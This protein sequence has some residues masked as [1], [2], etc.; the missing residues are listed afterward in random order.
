MISWPYLAGFTD[1][2]GSMSYSF[3]AGNEGR[4][5]R[6]VIDVR[7]GQSLRHAAVLY[8][9]REFLIQ[10]GCHVVERSHAPALGGPALYMAVTAVADV[11]LVLENMLP[12]LVLKQHKASQILWLIQNRKRTLGSR[13]KKHMR[14]PTADELAAAFQS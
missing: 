5:D 12:H 3:V 2:D 13:G 7:W 8:R 11:R 14:W 9:I 6:Y 4:H 1:G 10:H